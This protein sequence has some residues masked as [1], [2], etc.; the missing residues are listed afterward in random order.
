MA[1]TGNTGEYMIPCPSAANN[2]SFFGKDNPSDTYSTTIERDYPLELL[3]RP[4]WVAWKLGPPRRDGKRPK[5]PIDPSNGKPASTVDPLT[6]ARFERAWGHWRE[7]PDTITGVGY[8][9]REGDG[10]TGVD[11]DQCRDPA[12]GHIDPWAEE[13]IAPLDSYTAVTQSGKGVHILVDAT[14]NTDLCRSQEYHD[15]HAEFY[16]DGRFFA[17]TGLHL[18][19]TPLRVMPRQEALDRITADLDAAASPK[20]GKRRARMP[21]PASAPDS[22]ILTAEDQAI[23]QRA[24]NAANGRKF[25]ALWAGDWRSLDRYPSQS[26]ADS[27]LC[28]MLCYWFGFDD[29]GRIDRLFRASKLFRP[30]WDSRRGVST[31]GRQR[32]DRAIARH[33]EICRRRRHTDRNA[34]PIPESVVS[35][36]DPHTNTV[37]T[38]CPLDEKPLTVALAAEHVAALGMPAAANAYRCMG[39]RNLVALCNSF[40]AL[41]GEGVPFFL[42]CSDAA[43]YTWVTDDKRRAWKW[44]RRLE[45]DYVLRCVRRGIP[46]L[47]SGQST[48][49][50]YC[51]PITTQPPA[52]PQA[53]A[54]YSEL[55]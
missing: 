25:R 13:I 40:Q 29:P 27:A 52:E 18:P 54:E 4:N 41:S 3:D 17:L 23:I 35:K 50:V 32:I 38:G 55:I 33:P 48:E 10:I 26:E 21:G 34:S 12:T 11:L 20:A 36:G 53:P 51:L 1:A 8:A 14:K 42:S 37:R 43:K 22:V 19:G 47:G 9:F 39:L 2:P 24:M 49:W 7:N 30:K 5:L 28:D 15:G 46:V 31:Y 45:K 44:L 16:G 6:W